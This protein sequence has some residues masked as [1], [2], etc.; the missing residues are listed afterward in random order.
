MTANLVVIVIP[1]EGDSKETEIWYIK[2][3][4]SYYKKV[5]G[6][7][8]EVL[9]F[10][11]G[12]DERYENDI[13]M[14]TC[15]G[16]RDFA[17]RHNFQKA[18]IHAQGGLGAC[19][20]YEFLRYC[21]ERIARV[22][23]VG[24]APCEAMT[25]VATAFHLGFIRFW[26]RIRKIVPF[27]ADDPNPTNDETIAKIKDLSTKVMRAR[28]KMYRNQLLHIGQWSPLKV[29]RVPEECQVY[30]VPNGDTVRPRL[31]DNTYDNRKAEEA[32][33]RYG[34]LA[35]RK[36]GGNFSFYSMMPARELFVVMDEVR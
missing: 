17:Q 32:W 7:T 11:H 3:L 16:V 2:A 23:M 22:F 4:K 10:E 13:F 12:S 27:F 34:V 24:G 6:M 35:T 28:P 1:A 36:P 14:S 25:W 19:V 29:W 5:H 15:L 21:P 30:F 9:V 18:E 31:W 20:A 8:L 33:A 26:Y